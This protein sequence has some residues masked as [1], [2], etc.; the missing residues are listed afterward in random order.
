MSN[1][2]PE[3]TKFHELVSKVTVSNESSTS[4]FQEIL[5][6][7]KKNRNLT[8]IQKKWEK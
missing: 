1:K 3:G 7:V 4:I 2:E 8:I 5:L 6:W